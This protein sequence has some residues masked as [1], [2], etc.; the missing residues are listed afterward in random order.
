MTLLISSCIHSASAI[1]W[2]ERG[3][4]LCWLAEDLTSLLISFSLSGAV[5]DVALII[6]D[7]WCSESFLIHLWPGTR[8]HTYR[9]TYRAYTSTRTCT[10]HIHLLYCTCVRVNRKLYV[11][12]VIVYSYV[13]TSHNMIWNVHCAYIGYTLNLRYTGTSLIR[14][15]W[16]MFTPR[17]ERLQRTGIHYTC[18]HMHIECWCSLELAK[19]SPANWVTSIFNI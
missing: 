12:E 15:P 8:L 9:H 13:Y 16:K 17:L 10:L 6:R 11:H 19:T 7:V 4:S 5:R 2:G 18:I 3:S 14:T 1:A